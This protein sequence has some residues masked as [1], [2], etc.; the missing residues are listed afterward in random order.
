MALSGVAC[1]QPASAPSFLQA[2]TL[3]EG[4]PAVRLAA[5]QLELARGE[6]G[7]ASAFVSGELS[8]GY[9]RNLTPEAGEDFGAG[10][11]DPVTARATLNV[12]PFGDAADA[13]REAERAVRAAESAL[14]AARADAVVAAST[15]R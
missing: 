13:A 10:D 1:A 6:L 2:V 4:G 3:A 15:L 5:G 14:E 7:A 12:L 8:A 9:A 11:F